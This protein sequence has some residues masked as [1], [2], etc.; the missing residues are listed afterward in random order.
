[1][2][3]I[4]KFYAFLVKAYCFKNINNIE[5]KYSICKHSAQA[6]FEADPR[7]YA[8]YIPFG[9]IRIMEI[10]EPNIVFS[11]YIESVSRQLPDKLIVECRDASIKAERTWFR[12]EV[13]SHGETT[14]H[15]LKHFADM[16]KLDVSIY[17]AFSDV[18]EGH[19]WSAST[20][21][22]AMENIMQIDDLRMYPLSDGEI[23]IAPLGYGGDER[24]ITYYEQVDQ[25]LSDQIIR[26]KVIIWGD[27]VST[28]KSGSNPYLV[29]G[30]TRTV[31]ISTSLIQTQAGC[32]DLA[33]KIYNTFQEPLNIRTFRI[34]GDP[35]IQL[36][37][38]V[39]TPLGTGVVT[40]LTHKIDSERF[41]TEVTI[42][43]MC[44]SFF[45]IS[46]IK[47]EIYCSTVGHGVW[48]SMD[49]GIKWVDISG[50]QLYNSTVPAIHH[51]GEW[52]YAIR[53]AREDYPGEGDHV[54]YAPF[55][56]N[57]LWRVIPVLDSFIIHPHKVGCTDP[58]DSGEDAYVVYNKNLTYRDII[59]HEDTGD[60]YVVAYDRVLDL[61][62]V[63]I[64][65]SRHV[66]KESVFNKIMVLQ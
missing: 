10:T 36:N 37:D 15:W 60:I 63:L 42:G 56:A 20:A 23:R 30:E 3:Q 45:G 34:N 7:D 47:P 64:C 43:E 13:I 46:L 44:P 48:K 41:V 32:N 31:A 49:K 21:I 9:R 57:G 51:D 19:S 38:T 35:L 55:G 27:K 8:A 62:V 50:G 61:T 26:N 33:D 53:T 22:E 52:L 54:L 58:D 28:I 39:V 40:S 5:I 2:A 6:T 12:D 29:P 16:A 66:D 18:Y 1:M 11:G 25:S 14:A 65:T 24:I 17:G 4:N 59:T